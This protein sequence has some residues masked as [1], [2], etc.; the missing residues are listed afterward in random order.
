MWFTL[1]PPPN[2]YITINKNN[3]LFLFNLRTVF[4]QLTAG[5]TI[6][7]Q[8]NKCCLYRHRHKG[9]EKVVLHV[10][11][12]FILYPISTLSRDGKLT[13]VLH[14]YYKG[15]IK[16]SVWKMH[17]GTVYIVFVLWLYCLHQSGYWYIRN[18]HYAIMTDFNA[19]KKTCRLFEM[20]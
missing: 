19:H 13:G 10:V 15:H 17:L 2:K 18:Y 8:L 20:G 11:F 4:I 5:L 12:C 16:P 6:G 14:V 3:N 1:P 9:E 7:F